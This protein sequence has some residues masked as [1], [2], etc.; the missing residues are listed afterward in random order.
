[1]NLLLLARVKKEE[2][3]EEAECGVSVCKGFAPHV[4]TNMFS[5][6]GCFWV[7]LSSALV[8]VCS[9]S[10]ISPAWIVKEQMRSNNQHHHY[11]HK[12][13]VSFGL[14]W[15]CSESLDHMYRCYTFGGM[16]RFAEI[17][18]SSWQTS[19]VLCSGGCAL[20]AASSLL[21]IITVFLPSGGC[22]RRICTLAGYMQM[23]AVFIMAAGLLVYPFGL[24]SSLVRSFCGNSDVYN[25]GE[26]QIGWGY[27][28]AIVGV[29]L[30]IFLPFF[31]KYAPKEQLSPTPL[32]ALL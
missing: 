15:H 3:E 24:N 16:G 6:V 11:H 4:A 22:E 14:L 27:M 2:E 21:A 31:A 12:D 28:L 23:A 30:T 7:L 9:F 17:P 29:M 13:S 32:P 8:A 1:M 26:C 20:L 5:C 18:S 10:F 19:A 25:A